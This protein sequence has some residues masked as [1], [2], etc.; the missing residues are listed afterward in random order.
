MVKL[1]CVFSDGDVKEDDEDEE[2]DEDEEGDEDEGL[3]T[4]FAIFCR[5]A[6]FRFR[7]DII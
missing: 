3:Y 5:P 2:E 4:R 1:R 7:L 6:F